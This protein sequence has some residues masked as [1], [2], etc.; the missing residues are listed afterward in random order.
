[1]TLLLLQIKLELIK[2]KIKIERFFVYVWIRGFVNRVYKLAQRLSD[3]YENNCCD[4]ISWFWPWL[5]WQNKHKIKLKLTGEQ[6]HYYFNF[7]HQ[8]IKTFCKNNINCMFNP[9]NDFVW[10]GG[11]F[12]HGE[13]FWFQSSI[14][15]W[16]WSW[17]IGSVVDI[18]KLI[19]I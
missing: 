2:L 15:K 3:S 7:R 8:D 5:L 16:S 14:G 12:Q 18:S 17:S 11:W 9:K 10:R 1:M 13:Q 6:R 19:V 4:K